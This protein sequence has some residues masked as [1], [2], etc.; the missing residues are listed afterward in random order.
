MVFAEP[1]PQWQP[2]TLDPSMG[3]MICKLQKS[4]CGLRIAPRRWQDHLEQILRKCGFVPIMLNTCL[5]TRTTRRVSFV[6]HVDDLLLAGTH[7]IIQEVLAEL[8]RD[9]ELKSSEV[10]MKPTRY[11]G[12]TLVKT[13]K[14]VQH[15]SSCLVRGKHAGGAQHVRAQELTNTAAG[16]A[17][18]QMRNRCL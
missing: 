4:L 1:P 17:V 8:S 12:R 14:V 5:W 18:R 9:L 11:L 3:S 6:F 13:K 15:R 10:T 2:E 16:N 7:Q